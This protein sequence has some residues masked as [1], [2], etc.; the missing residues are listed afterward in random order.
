MREGYL[1]VDEVRLYEVVRWYGQRIVRAFDRLGKRELGRALL[2]IFFC[3]FFAEASATSIG[4]AALEE[5]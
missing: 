1:S 5:F 4:N 3:P 2:I